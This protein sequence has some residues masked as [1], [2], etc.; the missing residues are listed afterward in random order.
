MF[1][2]SRAVLFR[3]G[4]REKSH[5]CIARYL[6]ALYK[7]KL[8]KKWIDLLDYYRDLRHSGQYSTDFI[9]DRQE[10]EACLKA[11]SEFVVAIE[12]L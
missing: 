7:G 2:A 4:F 5:Y 10:A 12:K 6:E 11:A 1:H 8:S 3:D 9:A